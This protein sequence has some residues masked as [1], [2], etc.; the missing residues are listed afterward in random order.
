VGNRGMPTI[1]IP[2]QTPPTRLTLAYLEGIMLWPGL[3]DEA[4][5]A[6]YGDTV[7]AQ[8]VADN[9]PDLPLGP[10]GPEALRWIADAQPLSNIHE[11]VK[12]RYYE[13]CLAGYI[14]C[15]LIDPPKG[16]PAKNLAEA[17]RRAADGL[18]GALGRSLDIKRIDNVIWP[19]FKPVGHL[20]GAYIGNMRRSGEDTFPCR[21]DF[22]PKFLALACLMLRRGAAYRAPHSPVALLDIGNAWQL[23]SD[24]T[25]SVSGLTSE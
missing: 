2:S 10:L 19:R 16:T 25:R 20:W 5:R 23:P 24:V 21:L 13:G 11:R 1:N 12:S 22:L 14:L 8:Y 4:A 7:A 15:E 9:V 6:E 17:K 3:D 18:R